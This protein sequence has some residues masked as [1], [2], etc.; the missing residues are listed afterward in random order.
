[1]AAGV[2]MNDED[3]RPPQIGRRTILRATAW[4]VPAIVLATST[5]AFAVVSGQGLAL[6]HT[7]V[8]DTEEPNV[9]SLTVTY[10]Y[11]A[12]D[13]TPWTLS[14]IVAPDGAAIFD[15]SITFTPQQ[16][17][18]AAIELVGSLTLTALS[19]GSATVFVRA[20]R[21]GVIVDSPAAL[22]PPFALDETSPEGSVPVEFLV[23][24]AKP[25]NLQGGGTLLSWVG[26]SVRYQGEAG[27][28]DEATV[29]YRLE[30]FYD[31]GGGP[32]TL[33]LRTGTAVIGIRETGQVTDLPG[34]D[35]L[36]G[37]D[38][39]EPLEPGAYWVRMTVY[40]SDGSLVD[41]TNV[42]TIV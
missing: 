32:V 35:L 22:L 17:A 6:T 3:A 1:M 15:G 41:E 42:E 30:F 8:G 4:S 7:G 16:G 39:D 10:L 34:I 33:R 19:T 11:D 27:G 31:S 23:V 26:G 40:G 12:L 2:R 25:L 36:W 9:K 28:P 37:D 20:T 18:T 5:P 29:G 13:S 21:D 24:T 14:V 38:P